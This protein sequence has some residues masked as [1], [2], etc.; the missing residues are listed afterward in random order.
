V[1]E[2]CGWPLKSAR[3]TR[4]S[5]PVSAESRNCSAFTR[6]APDLGSKG[7]GRSRHSSRSHQRRTLPPQGARTRGARSAPSGR[8]PKGRLDFLRNRARRS[9]EAVVHYIDSRRERWGVEP[10]CKVLQFA[11]ATYYATKAR[12]TCARARRDEALEPEITRVHDASLDGVY[13]AKKV[14]KQLRREGFNVARCTVERL[15]KELGLS[16]VRKGR[17]YKITTIGDESLAQPSDSSS[18]VTSWPVRPIACGSRTSPTSNP[19]RA[20]STPPS[21]STCSRGRSWAGTRGR[22]SP[23]ASRTP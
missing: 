8:D 3:A 2:P 22:C 18:I 10:I 1:N 9:N 23:C 21:S 13:G 16:G 14:W 19:S 17:H 4:P 11:P 20:G 6:D 7:L 5:G 15:M 12:P